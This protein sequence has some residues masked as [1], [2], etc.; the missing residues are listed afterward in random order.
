MGFA[1]HRGYARVDSTS[2]RAM[3]ECDRCRAWYNLDDLT[4]QYQWSG[5]Q[6]ANTGL[7]V[8]RKQCL[9]VP[10]EQYRVLILPGDPI[11]RQNARPSPNT[12][13]PGTEG[14]PLPTPP[15]NQG[16]TGYALG[17]PQGGLYT[18]SNADVLAQIA[19]LSGVP[20][21]PGVVDRSITIAAPG[22]TQAILPVNGSRTWLLIYSPTGAQAV[23]S[24]GTAVF[25]SPTILPIGPGQAYFWATAQGLGAVYQG[26]MTAAGLLAGAP[27]WC[28]ESNGTGG[29]N[30]MQ[31]G[32]GN[33]MNDGSGNIMEST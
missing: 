22:A 11:P 16:F 9:D 30:P 3:A 2:P 25:G 7:L 33:L 4:W 12:T 28:F 15:Q 18:A 32:A 29:G 13:P 20:T 1:D 26:A 17:V 19:A 21:P 23:I 10:F 24:T 14:F 6:L 8:C 27:L 31:D 5:A